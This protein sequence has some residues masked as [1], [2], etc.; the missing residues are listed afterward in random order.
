MELLHAVLTVAAIAAIG[1]MSPG[2]D[3]FAVTYASML[4]SRMQAF[5][6]ALGVV[7]GNGIWAG[8]ALLGVGALF[9]LF[10]T[11]YLSFKIFGALYLCY[12]GIKMLRSARK[13]LPE[14]NIESTPS[15]TY[16]LFSKGLATTMSNPKAAV[17]YASALSAAAPQHA[18]WP[19]LMALL[20]TVI[21]IATVWFSLV[22]LVLS[23]PKA[24][25]AFRRFKAYFE[26]LF[27]GLLL[28]FGLKRLW[29]A[30]P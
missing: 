26:S 23:T 2:P 24:S 10:P 25:A 30:K 28:T 19:T 12:L 14:S 29:D 22:I 3:F 6:V 16:A 21:A 4:Q 13:P 1:I 5:W 18:S 20:A 11:F 9:A 17:Y 7:C 15:S 27:G 8:A